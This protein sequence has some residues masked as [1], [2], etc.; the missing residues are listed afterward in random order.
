MARNRFAGPC[1]D[2]GQTV[3]PGEGYFERNAGRTLVR[4]VRC[5][6]VAKRAAGAPLSRAQ[7]Q[8]LKAASASTPSA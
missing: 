4:H 7:A 2:C 8:A 1:K 6:A 5:T 3:E